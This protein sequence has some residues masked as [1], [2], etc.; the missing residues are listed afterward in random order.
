MINLHLMRWVRCVCLEMLSCK[1]NANAQQSAQEVF[2]THLRL[3][4]DAS[5]DQNRHCWHFI[6]CNAVRLRCVA[7]CHGA[8]RSSDRTFHVQNRSNLIIV[9]SGF[10]IQ[11]KG[12]GISRAWSI[13]S[14]IITRLSFSNYF[15]YSFQCKNDKCHT[16]NWCC[17]KDPLGVRE[18]H[19]Q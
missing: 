14:Q 12:W 1:V 7:L 6:R 17:T 18:K 16:K 5:I 15:C 10:S 4:C 19:R 13:Y 3:T 9:A 2:V 11:F 8:L